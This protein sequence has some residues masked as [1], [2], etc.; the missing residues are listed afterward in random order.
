[1]DYKEL[2]EEFKKDKNAFGK[3]YNKLYNSLKYFIFKYVRDEDYINDILSNTFYRIY[4]KID[5]YNPELSEFNT[6]CF[7][8]AKNE[9]LNHLN[10][11]KKYISLDMQLN[12]DDEFTLHDVLTNEDDIG[13]VNENNL[14]KLYSEVLSVLKKNPTNY[15]IVMYKYVNNLSN[16]EIVE[17]INEKHMAG[18][19]SLQKE[20]DL[21][22]NDSGKY[23][24]MCLRKQEYVS[25]N[26]INESFVKNRILK[27]EEKLS[28]YFKKYNI[29]DF[30]NI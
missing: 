1:M 14:Q 3:I 30:L 21:A 13:N 2:I 4:N 24:E 8:I 19:R 23:R 10:R 27:T 16:M 29:T 28:E 20:C 22:L 17:R 15:E 18:Y 11:Q 5:S 7:T 12:D 26:M 9:C 6:W 25:K